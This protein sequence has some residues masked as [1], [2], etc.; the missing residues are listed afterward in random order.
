MILLGIDTSTSMGGAALLENGQ[1][2]A[3]YNLKIYNGHSERILPTILRILTDSNLSLD[4]VSAFTVV[5]G[6]GSFTG[7]RV[8]LAT[9]KGFA[10]ALNKPIITVT[11]LQALAWQYRNYPYLICPII[12]ARRNEVF[13]Q[14]F[15]EGQALNG[16]INCRV[17]DLIAKLEGR[18]KPV[19]FVGEGVLEYK[20]QLVQLKQGVL[21]DLESLQL[22]SG[23]VASLGM[24]LYNQGH[25]QGWHEALPFYMR[26]SSAEYQQDAMENKDGIRRK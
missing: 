19:L 10:Y 15:Q 18:E 5:S 8:G 22:R 23:S 6:P 1:I 2:L 9:I 14:L 24:H 17:E 7:L 12:D 16:P 21:A 4:C 25:T 26:K 11:S 3:E 13:T 20:Q